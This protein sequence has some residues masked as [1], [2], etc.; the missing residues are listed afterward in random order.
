MSL[1]FSLIFTQGVCIQFSQLPEIPYLTK[2]DGE[3]I[4]VVPFYVTQLFRMLAVSRHA[5]GHINGF[6]VNF[7]QVTVV[8]HSRISRTSEPRNFERWI[9]NG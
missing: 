8:G 6:A 4:T 2:P 5:A 7:C 1:I 3:I 9:E